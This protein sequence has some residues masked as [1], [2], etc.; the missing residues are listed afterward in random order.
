[1]S[2]VN[3]YTGEELRD[4]KRFQERFEAHITESR[5]YRHHVRPPMDYRYRPDT[6]MYN[7]E[8]KVEPCVAIH[9]P[10]YQFDRLMDDQTRMDS[11]RSEAEYGKKI[12]TM[13][14]KDERVRDENP[15]VA[16]AY[17]NYLTL[18]ELARK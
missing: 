13:L 16:K 5:E 4:T 18:L 6:A 14:H 3:K 9:M 1:M 11:W 17:R 2:Y 8:Y 15:A 12:L 10:G 7:I